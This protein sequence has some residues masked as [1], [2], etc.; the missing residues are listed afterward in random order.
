MVQAQGFGSPDECRAYTGE[1]HVPC[2]Y[3]YIEMEQRTLAQIEESIHRQT[4]VMEQRQERV[5]Q[6]AAAP[7]ETP[8]TVTDPAAAPVFTYPPV[9]PGYAH[10]GLWVSRRTLRLS[11]L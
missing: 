9:A 6:Q 5:D 2:L 11:G 3:A 8:Q 7:Q 10:A 4:G 1:T